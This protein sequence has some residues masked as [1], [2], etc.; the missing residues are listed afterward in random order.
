MYTTHY[1]ITRDEHADADESRDT[2]HH[3]QHLVQHL[4]AART[5]EESVI[6]VRVGRVRLEGIREAEREG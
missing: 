6:L 3:Q 5:S 2:R 4:A 1:T